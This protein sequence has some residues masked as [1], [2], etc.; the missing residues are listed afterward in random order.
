MALTNTPQSYGAVER[1]LHWLM[2]LAIL[3]AI[4]LG[5]IARRLPF[6]TAEALAGKAWVFSLHK[7]LGVALLVLALI[8]ILWAALQPRPVP[9][10]P[11]RRLETAAAALVHGALYLS[12]ISVPLAGWIEHSAA[13][14]FA[15][16]L[17]PFG[18][19]LPFVPKSAALAETAGLLH[20]TFAWI[21]IG[22]IA[23]HVAGALKHAL[24]DRDDTLARMTRGKAA[25][26]GAGA[27][28][29]GPA[30]AALAIYAIAAG[31]A[32]ALM[33]AGKPAAPA[34]APVAS[35]WQVTDGA[36]TFTLRQMGSEVEG[37]FPDWTAAIRFDQTPVE[38]RHGE[39]T[40]TIA[41]ETLTLGSVSEQA[42]APEFFDSAAHPTATFT[43]DILPEGADYVARGRLTLRGVEVP[44]ALPF[45]L[46]IEGDVARM[47]GAL[48]LDRRDFGMGK[49]YPDEASVG[50]AVGV[51]VVLTAQ[52]AD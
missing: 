10:H 38:G 13:T 15:P 31:G 17:W 44:V 28:H 8:R 29:R 52:R 49:S 1:T 40:V 45:R 26:R 48:Q 4:T 20:R 33:P 50:H 23:L 14:G 30:L 5:L 6:D 37:R 22:A 25:G 19:S 46:V 41:T 18:Q 43:A 47:E 9:L 39:V 21:M 34:L 7:S 24:V 27:R 35:G 3:T 12:L 2:A 42:K 11:Q 36:L 16:I 32:L 51:K